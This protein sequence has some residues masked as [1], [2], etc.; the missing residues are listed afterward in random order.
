MA[1]AG[2]VLT[3]LGA[4]TTRSQPFKAQFN[5]ERPVR[6]ELISTAA[7]QYDFIECIV[8]KGRAALQAVS[9]NAMLQDSKPRPKVD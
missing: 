6:L 5:N 3:N 8:T 1:L 9:G 4:R 2:L 7:C